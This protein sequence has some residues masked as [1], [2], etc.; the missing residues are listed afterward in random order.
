MKGSPPGRLML[1]VDL[2]E[3]F[4]SRRWI[5]G[6]QTRALA[7]TSA[8]VSRAADASGPAPPGDLVAPTQALLDLYDRHQVRTTFFILGEVAERYP[9]LV[10]E[11]ARR[12]HEIGSHGFVHVDMTVLGP[13]TFA[14]HLARSVD[15]LTALTGQRPAGYRA[16]NLV[17]APWATRVLEA[18]GFVYDASVAVSRP[19]G[20]KYRGWTHAPHH[21]YHPSYDAI[22]ERG[23][24]TLIEIPLPCVPG[25]RLAAGSGILTRTFGLSWSLIAL[26]RTIRTGDTSY[27]FHPWEVAPRPP[28]VGSRL[29]S[30]LFYRHTGAWMMRAIDHILTEFRGR[31][32]PGIEIAR[33]C[34]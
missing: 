30:A 29:R 21:P 7:D 24:A 23:D 27:Y 8:L 2:D 32:V 17:Y 19:I 13:E 26:R 16:P 5:D 33:A 11:I 20:G 10:R 14:A 15:V 22:G 9:S 18:Q 28:V 1:S 31:I 34:R 3:W 6:T 25:L 12:G 4:H